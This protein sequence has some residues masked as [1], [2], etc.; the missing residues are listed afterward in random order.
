MNQDEIYDYFS[1]R[2]P[3]KNILT[4]YCDLDIYCYRTGSPLCGNFYYTYDIS[5]DQQKVVDN[6]IDIKKSLLKTKCAKMLDSARELANNIPDT[7]DGF[8]NAFEINRLMNSLIC[9]YCIRDTEHSKRFKW[10]VK[11]SFAKNI[12]YAKKCAAKM[13]R[14]IMSICEVNGW[15]RESW[16]FYFDY[17]QNDMEIKTLENLSKKF[18][19]IG[20]VNQVIGDS[21]FEISFTPKEYESV[22]FNLCRGYMPKNNFLDGRLDY[23]RLNELT[24][25][26]NEG[27]FD[28][29]YKGGIREFCQ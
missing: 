3:F 23:T 22:N 29:L 28:A 16:N 5:Y 12:E 15:E 21:F 1:K 19:Q 24:S 14:P 7:I 8:K 10:D 13:K 25:M 2:T 11:N 6:L 27:C 4:K 18:Q 17:P 20:K 26:S 9:D